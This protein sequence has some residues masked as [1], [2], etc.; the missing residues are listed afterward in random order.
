MCLRGILRSFALATVLAFACLPAKAAEESLFGSSEVRSNNISSFT[1]WTGVLNRYHAMAEL[2]EGLCA[3]AAGG[4]SYRHESCAWDKW[5]H[6]LDEYKGE[7]QME[8]LRGVNDTFNSVR[9]VEDSNNWG[10]QDYWETVFEFLDR[11]AGDCEDY[12]I[13]KY[14]TLRKLGWPADR[15]R[16]VI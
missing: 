16:I 2:G 6:I 3:T 14:V 15:L 12:A 4:V 9:Y 8:Q 13:S 5:E 10:R 7:S 11:N 1:N